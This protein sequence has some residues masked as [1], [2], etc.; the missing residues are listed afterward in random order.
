MDHKGS[1]MQWSTMPKTTPGSGQISAD[2]MDLALVSSA[3]L[4]T[5]RSITSC[6]QNE[7]NEDGSE[8]RPTIE[9]SAIH[10]KQSDVI[11]TSFICKRL[12]LRKSIF[13]SEDPV[14]LDLQESSDVPCPSVATSSFIYSPDNK[15]QMT[16]ETHNV[17]GFETIDLTSDGDGRMRVAQHSVVCDHS[18]LDDPRVITTDYQVVS[19]PPTRCN[20]RKERIVL[21]LIIVGVVLVVTVI[22]ITGFL[23][24]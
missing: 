12:G 16:T 18:S 22:I 21:A 10:Q 2:A 17:D 3:I 15:V 24:F 20:Q 8:I 6:S 9:P 19:I 11:N 7:S 1:E 4:P 13:S 23:H 5:S 14:K